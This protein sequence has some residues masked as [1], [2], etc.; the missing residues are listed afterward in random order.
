[1]TSTWTV[2][3][4][5]GGETAY[6][7]LSEPLISLGAVGFTS[8]PEQLHAFFKD[9]V[10][11]EALLEQAQTLYQPLQEEAILPAGEITIEVVAEEDWVGQWRR[12]LGPILAGDRFV[13]IPPGVE[14]EPEPG[15][16]ALRLEPRMAFGTGEHATTRMALALLE[17]TVHEGDRVLDLGCGNGVLAIGAL[18]LGA[19]SAFGIDNEQEA[20]DETLENAEL[21]GVGEKLRALFGD[22]LA[23]PI[24]GSYDLL[25][26]NIFVTPI[27]AGLPTWL[28]QMTPDA[29]FIF[30]GVQVGDEEKRLLEGV[31]SMGLEV[32]ETLHLD[33][34][35][36]ARCR[37][38]PA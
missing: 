10:S 9:I 16:I 14:A 1:M 32:E 15:R 29:R 31:A 35:I 13:V 20:V 22:V 3:H 26:A 23:D 33:G 30:T 17:K 8:D 24:E 12:S 25:L 37:R 11:Q 36:A 34:W 27:L 28:K 5:P 7:L 18:L 19:G 2:I 21:H 6:E 4:L 38:L